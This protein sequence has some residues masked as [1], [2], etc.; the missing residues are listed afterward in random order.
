MWLIFNAQASIKKFPG[1]KSKVLNDLLLAKTIFHFYPGEVIA[2]VEILLLVFF[3]VVNI[4]DMNRFVVRKVKIKTAKKIGKKSVKFVLLSDLHSKEFDKG[5][6]KLLKAIRQ[7]EP[8]FIV[9]AGDM[10]TATSRKNN[11]PAVS[12]V[13]E[14]TKD[15]KV[16][17]G[18]GNHEYRAKIYPET[19]AGMYDDFMQKIQSGNLTV[20]DNDRV[21][22]GDLQIIGL[23]IEREYYKKFK[24]IHMNPEH[25]PELIG[26]PDPNKYSI[27]IA[28]N[29]QYGEAYFEYPA[30]LFVSGHFHGCLIR[31]PFIGGIISPAF[32][33][34]PKYNGGLY[35][36]NGRYGYVSCGIGSHT[37]PIRFYN[38]GEV[39]EITIEGTGEN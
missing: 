32:R 7:C 13:N 33:L 36:K 18:L 34:F 19:Y 12:F 29:P 37:L 38:P 8:D 31:L 14:L 15:Y 3:I 24:R 2:I 1:D 9:I 5:N 26:M 21:T 35:Q 10:L 23:S 6:K 25:V 22:V 27:L 20:L 39:T 30:D 28:H 17:F 11:S 4:V 16:Y